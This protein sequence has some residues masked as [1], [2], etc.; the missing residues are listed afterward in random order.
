MKTSGRMLRP[1]IALCAALALALLSAPAFGEEPTGTG[2]S[3]RVQSPGAEEQGRGSEQAGLD[4]DPFEPFNRVM[5]DVNMKF[6][7]HL[8][9]P[10]ARGW[11]FVFPR[12]VQRS[13]GNFYDNLLFPIHI[14]NNLLQGDLDPAAITLTRFAVNTTVGLAGLFDPV[15]VGDRLQVDERARVV[16]ED[17][18]L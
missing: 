11:D 6:D 8:L 10:A 7:E 17:F 1:E 16:G 13:I 12:A 2:D 14:I 18:I 3:P 15:Q 4:E 9:E 5:F